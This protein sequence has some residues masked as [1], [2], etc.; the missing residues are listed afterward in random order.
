MQ[1]IEFPFLSS[2]L[3]IEIRL[4]LSILT[5]LLIGFILVPV[6]GQLFKA[7]MGFNLYNMGFTA[8][9]VGILIVAMYKSYGFGPKPVMAWTTGNNVLLGS[10]LSATLA[11]MI[12]AGFY[13]DRSALTRLN[14]CYIKPDRLPMIL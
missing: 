13:L 10:F 1:V 12:L 5:S 8:G 9:V 11:S 2:I 7:H 6:A 3:A 4:P 14:G